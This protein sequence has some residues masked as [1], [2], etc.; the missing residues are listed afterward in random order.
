MAQD[1]LLEI[2]VE[3][4]PASFVASSLARLP[5]LT[6]GW[7]RQL[8]LE[9][10]SLRV[11]GTPRRLAVL[12]QQVAEVQSDLD[13]EV[14]GPPV[15]VS[16]DSSG[17]PTKAATSF[18]NKHG[19]PVEA[20]GRVQ[21]PRGEYVALHRKEAGSRA[22]AL[23]PRAFEQLCGELPFSKS[24]RWGDG[25]TAFGRPVRWLVVLFGNEV[26]SLSFAGVQSGQTTRGHRFLC[27]DPVRLES[28]SD[29]VALL[30]DRH[31]LVDVAERRNVMLQSLRETAAQVG[32]LMIEDELLV[33]ENLNLV[34]EPHVIAGSFSSE[35]LVLP[36]HVVLQVGKGHQR[37]FGVR[38]ATGKLLPRYLAVL[39]TALNPEAIRLG[40]DRVMRAR[41]ADAKFFFDEDLRIPLADRL[42]AL[43]GLIF[44][45][46][47]GSVGEKVLRIQALVSALG[48][49]LRLP[50]STVHQ[51]AKAAA[52]CKCDLV[53]LMVGE[54][55]EL[56]GEMGCVYALEQGIEGP[57]ARAI[58]EHYQPRGADDPPAPSDPG[59][60]VAIA[61]RMDT[62]VGCFAIG[63]SPSGAAD[64]LGLRRAAI[65]ILRTLLEKH[66][67]LSLPEALEAAYTGFANL[68]LDLDMKETRDKVFGFLR[69]RLRGVL[70]EPG[71]VVDACIAAAAERPQ[72]V[73]LRVAALIAIDPA[74]RASAGEVFKRAANIA[75][76]APDGEPR[77]PEKVLS[78]VHPSEK[79]LFSEFTRLRQQLERAG[80]DG[81]YGAAIGA[82]GEFAPT[83]G[84]FFDD[85]FVM[86]DDAPVRENR[87]RLMRQ[88]HR[89]CSKLANFNLLSGRAE[90]RENAANVAAP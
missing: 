78:E 30:R 71:D 27:P 40:N 64:P 72:D 35:F 25:E 6:A 56:Q 41:L 82:I 37:Y 55:P 9:H 10:G 24:M 17:Q 11:Y 84:K 45:N 4:L 90:S 26:L 3:E 18:A 85:V 47:L 2:G 74:V 86:V 83:L 8:R 23:L 29:Y 28:P 89:T 80:S 49:Q 57:V 58:A 33:E 7:L 88:I 53:T 79:R 59:A 19:A 1:L 39:G 75:K 12:V 70:G 65:G 42:K 68:R 51:A 43:E 66:W 16:F 31:V 81:D 60:L 20:L 87:L 61:D 15:R 5:E 54:L 22:G 21:T 32:G 73:A 44:Q 46:R 38:D 76:Q 77:P 34:E 13:E 69:H 52:L 63:L 50:E 67:D 36:E 14:L 48:Q 62:L